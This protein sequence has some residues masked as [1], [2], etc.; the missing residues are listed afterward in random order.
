MTSIL[1]RVKTSLPIV[2]FHA[3]LT[4]WFCVYQPSSS[5][6]AA[7]ALSRESGVI[8]GFVG[9]DTSANLDLSYVPAVHGVDEIDNLVDAEFRLVLRKM[10]KRDVTTRLKVNFRVIHVMKMY[11]QLLYLLPWGHNMPKVKSNRRLVGCAKVSLIVSLLPVF[12]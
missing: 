4:F 9:F 2:C 10:S 5:S 8:P 3:K 11:Y 12:F 7:E 1:T 6:R